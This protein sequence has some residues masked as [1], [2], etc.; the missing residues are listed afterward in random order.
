[1]KH[2]GFIL[3]GVFALLLS[4]CATTHETKTDGKTVIIT[5]DTTVV[6]HRGNG[7]TRI[8]VPIIK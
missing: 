3:V 1:M 4:S 6:Y 2:F 5:T 7:T 8:N